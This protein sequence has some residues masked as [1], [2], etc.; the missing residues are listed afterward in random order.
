MST[1]AEKFDDGDKGIIP[2]AKM[3]YTTEEYD[4]S[5]SGENMFGGVYG[6]DNPVIVENM[7][8]LFPDG[9]TLIRENVLG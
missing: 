6:Y 1:M 4:F 9:S 2:I 7:F 8:Y 3:K 5:E